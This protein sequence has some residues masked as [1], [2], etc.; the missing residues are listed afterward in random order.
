MSRL[1]VAVLSITLVLA[2]CASPRG[3]T[4]PSD[5]QP[6]PTQPGQG[7]PG[8]PADP[9]RPAADP[10]GPA[11]GAVRPKPGAPE[12]PRE[13]EPP[14]VSI[15]PPQVLQ[16]DFTTLR[17]DRPVEGEVTV[18]VEGLWEQPKVFRHRGRPVAFIGFPANARVGT[19][20][21]AVTWP[22]GEWRGTIEL[23]YKQFT[24]DRLVV[25]EEQEQVYYDPRAADQWRRVFALRSE[26]HPV[27]L[28]RGPFR[29]PLEG[30]QHITTYFGEI[31][32]VNGKETGRHSGMDFGAP[33][34][35]PVLAPAR[36]RVILA[37]E[38][39]VPGRIV[40]LDHGQNLFTAYYH[41]G[42]I[43]VEPGQMVQAGEVIGTVGSTGFSTGPHLHWT[44]TIGNIPVDP[45]PLTRA[46][47][48]GIPA[49]EH[50]RFEQT[51]Q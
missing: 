27:P 41:L 51:P 31:R 50:P 37:E 48:L 35:T 7:R 2:G 4:P 38:M 33:T 24:E 29:P 45:W 28:W 17:L 39:I 26:S 6:A 3:G 11:P 25:T 14:R 5:E 22:G 20:P 9:D 18:H 49:P 10:G 32:Y 40:I 8:A 13:P 42:S 21:V 23:V 19:Y 15:D 12:V 36:G 1:I 16:G 43:A 30:P 46:S 47:P 34:G 44:A